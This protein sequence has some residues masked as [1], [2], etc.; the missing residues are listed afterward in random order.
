MAEADPPPPL[1]DFTAAAATAFPTPSDCIRKKRRVCVDRLLVRKSGKKWLVRKMATIGQWNSQSHS[2]LMRAT[3]KRYI[4][5]YT[6][7]D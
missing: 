5:C 2:N 7:S 1:A 3:L 4:Y 6:K